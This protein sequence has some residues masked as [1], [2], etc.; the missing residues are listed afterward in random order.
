MLKG[1]FAMLSLAVAA[2][3]CLQLAGADTV[4]SGVVDPCNSSASGASGSV[5]ACP[6]GD[7]TALAAGGLTISVTVLDD[8][9][10]PVVGVAA[11]D[12][13]L[14][15]CTDALVLCGGSGGINAAAAT[16]I[17]G[18]TTITGDIAG[19][20]CDVGVRVVVQGIVIGAGVCADPCVPLTVR[21]PDYK[22]ESPLIVQLQDFAKFGVPFPSPPDAYDACSDFVA[23]FLNINLQDFSVFGLHWLHS[24]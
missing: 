3:L 9:N 1:K 10:A 24:C 15:G 20:G 19:G 5:V 16:D 13:W 2:L 12:I 17:N 14:I 22:L 8:V 4:S 23:P 7:G 18:Q 6:Q 21:S 11:A